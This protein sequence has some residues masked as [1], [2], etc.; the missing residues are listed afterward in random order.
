MKNPQGFFQDDFKL[1]S[2]LTLNLGLRWFGT[3]GFSE[4]KGHM[5]TFD[6]KV[7]NGGTGNDP[8]GNP[9]A[10]QFG[11]MWYGFSHA[12]GRTTLQAPVY[13][14][15]LPRVGFSWS[16]DTKTVVRGGVGLYNYSW[17]EDTYGG[18]MGGGAGGGGGAWDPSNGIYYQLQMDSDGSANY[19]GPQNGGAAGCTSGCWGKSVKNLWVVSPTTPYA[20]NG[21]G[22]GYNMYH[23]PVPKIWQYNLTIER[24]IGN[25]MMGSLAYVG[26]RGWGLPFNVDINQVHAADLSPTDNTP[27]TVK[28]PNPSS[29]ESAAAPITHTPTTTHFRPYSRNAWAMAWNSTPTLCIRNSSIT[30]TPPA[31]EAAWAPPITRTPIA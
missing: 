27:G 20:Q 6:P 19:E 1:R 29:R 4:V 2:N 9:V 21:N 18:G 14:T 25:T 26:S 7:V 23:T 22:P 13:S 15:F 17:S 5:A 31:G 30:W 8:N 12:N 11:G 3:T 16:Y 24:Q 28:R 10:N